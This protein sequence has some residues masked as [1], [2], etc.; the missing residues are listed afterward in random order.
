[1]PFPYRA[2]RDMSGMPAEQGLAGSGAATASSIRQQPVD[3]VG[4]VTAEFVMH[5][6]ASV[7]DRLEEEDRRS[8]LRMARRLTHKRRGR[9]PGTEMD[10]G[11]AN[12]GGKM[13]K[14]MHAGEKFDLGFHESHFGMGAKSQTFER[15]RPWV[16][17]DTW[18]R[19]KR[20]SALVEYALV[21]LV[22]L[23]LLFAIAVLAR[24]LQGHHL[25]DNAAHKATRHA[26]VRASNG[27][28][29]PAA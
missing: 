4:E 11:A 2:F 24:T 27:S 18:L 15:A 26:L 20:R 6:I 1:M 13:S 21:A 17:P 23:A 19:E 12:T 14:Y 28:V 25:A 29:F 8:L 9:S 10:E 5:N 22:F 3:L 16:P 7:L